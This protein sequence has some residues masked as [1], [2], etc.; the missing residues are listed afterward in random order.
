[1]FSVS[2]ASASTLIELWLHS[3]YTISLIN[4]IR[5]LLHTPGKS[6]DKKSTRLRSITFAVC[7]FLYINCTF[8]LALG[9]VVLVQRSN[10]TTPEIMD[11]F[12]VTIQSLVADM[13]LIY[14]CWIINA[15]SW[16]VI[17][18]PT[19]SWLAG[20]GLSLYILILPLVKP[21]AN[22]ADAAIGSLHTFLAAKSATTI[23]VNIYA[24]GFILWRILATDCETQRCQITDPVTLSPAAK[25]SICGTICG[26]KRTQL[27][28]TALIL[29]EAAVPY[30]I[31]SIVNFVAV[32]LKS[33][34]SYITSAINIVLIGMTF[35]QIITCVSK[36]RMSR[37]RSTSSV[38]DM[39]EPE[40]TPR[41]AY[42][43]TTSPSYVEHASL[44][45]RVSSGTLGALEC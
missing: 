9:L 23:S 8:N 14:R 13:F 37:E 10:Y 38:G 43:S 15:K 12:N 19:L 27:Q 41:F 1:M 2:S 4:A 33:R 36:A 16:T 17:M 5:H 6:L 34:V 25:C 26:K 29:L 11:T 24:T 31:V 18:F 20:T 45:Q 3:L 44:Q 22:L 7:I 21:H 35:N 42:N 30:T 32:V 40:L 28:T 39:P